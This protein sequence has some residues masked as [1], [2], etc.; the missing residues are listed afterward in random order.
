[1]V[2]DTFILPPIQLMPSFIVSRY[3]VYH[4]EK[5]ILCY[6]FRK[7]KRKT[8]SIDVARIEA[9]EQFLHGTPNNLERS[10]STPV[11]NGPPER[12]LKVPQ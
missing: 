11:I 3:F 5:T 6:N 7:K 4:Y 10:E 12:E 9:L 2:H 8:K 1:M